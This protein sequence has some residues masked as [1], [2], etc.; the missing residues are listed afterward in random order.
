[1]LSKQQ[2]TPVA[3][4]ALPFTRLSYDHASEYLWENDDGSTT[5]ISQAEG[6]EQGDPLM[7]LLFCLG[8]HDP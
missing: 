6:G 3:R 8:I 4:D 2:R 1:M 5:T 7:P